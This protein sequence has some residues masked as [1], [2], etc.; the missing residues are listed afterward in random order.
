M[1][2]RDKMT[3]FCPVGIS[4]GWHFV[5]TPLL[6]DDGLSNAERRLHFYYKAETRAFIN[7][8]HILNCETKG[9]WAHT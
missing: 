8:F 4:S 7:G 6:F 5:R 9:K 2:C 3:T 1:K